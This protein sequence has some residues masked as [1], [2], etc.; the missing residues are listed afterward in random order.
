MVTEK[1]GKAYF[2]RTGSAPAKSHAYFVR[3]L[4]ALASRAGR[5]R[6]K[7]AESF[8]FRRADD[9][10]N[11]IPTV[12]PLAYD[13]ER[14]S[15]DLAGDNGPNSE[16]PWPRLAPA[17]AP[18]SFDFDVWKQLTETG[19]GKQLIRVIDAAISEFPKFA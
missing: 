15:P 13:L 6:Q 10:E 16:Y 2:W 11:W 3:F 12:T 9:F 18:A 8:G 14:L 1:L 17:C 4:R 7:I 19:R 5:D